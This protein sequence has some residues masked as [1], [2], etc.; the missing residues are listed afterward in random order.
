MLQF[1]ILKTLKKILLFQQSDSNFSPKTHFILQ[2]IQTL[3]LYMFIFFLLN[4][5]LFVI[6]S[7]C[8]RPQLTVFFKPFFF[9][10]K[11]TTQ[12]NDV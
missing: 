4:I 10:K 3:Y 9:L 7:S 11:K 6:S 2:N 1:Q 12:D 5:F 8:Y